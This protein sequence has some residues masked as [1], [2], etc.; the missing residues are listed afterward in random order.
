MKMKYTV[1]KKHQL[2]KEGIIL[3]SNKDYHFS[4]VWAHEFHKDEIDDW[5]ETGWIEE[6]QELEFTKKDMIIFGN[7]CYHHNPSFINIENKLNEYLLK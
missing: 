6:V 3:E 2:L 1:T 5:I 7:I 4:S